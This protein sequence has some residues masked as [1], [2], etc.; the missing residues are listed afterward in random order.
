MKVQREL[1]LAMLEALRPGVTVGELQVR[2]A[3][4]AADVAP[5]AGPAAGATGVLVMHGRGMGDDGPIITGH[6]RDPQQ[7][8]VTL[9]ERMV[10]ILKPQ[11]HSVGDTHNITWGDTVVVTTGGAQRLGTREHGIAF[12]KG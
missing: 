7:L 1:F 8:A 12:A 5:R 3:R 10:F 2:C 4:K 9:R 11:V 6:A